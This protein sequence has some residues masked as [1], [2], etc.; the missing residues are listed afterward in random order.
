MSASFQKRTSNFLV[1]VLIGFIVISFMFTGYESMRGTP[2]TVARVGDYSVKIR[3]YQQEYQRQI[4]FYKN[5]FGG[6]DLTSAQI[7]QFGLKKNT[8]NNLVQRKLMLVLGDKLGVSP[9]P[10]QI[11]D[12][13]KK[14]PYFLTNK[15]FDINKYKQLLA[16]N[17]FT[18]TDFEQDTIQQVKGQKTQALFG[19]F[20]LSDKYLD[21]VIKFKSNKRNVSMVSIIREAM[22]KHVSVS[23]NEVNTFLSKTEDMERVKTMFN[24][25]KDSLSQKEQVRAHHILLKT[26]GKNDAAILKKINKVAAEVNTG[27]FKKLASKYTEDPSGK[28]TGGAL[29]WFGRGAMVPAFEKVAFSL[30]RG[31]ISSPV[32]TKFGYHIIYV[33]GKKRAKEAKLATH[34]KDIAKELIRRT[35]DKELEALLTSVSTQVRDAIYKGKKSTVERLKKKYGFQFEG[36]KELNSYDGTGGSIFIESANLKKIF[37]D[38]KNKRHGYVFDSAKGKQVVVVSPFKAKKKP[39]TPKELRAKERKGLK[40][41]LAKKLNEG[42]M[43]NLQDNVSVKVF[44]QILR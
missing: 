18:P 36:D 24:E 29:N 12:E 15:Q 42:M 31:S 35:K 19:E 5:I 38:D 40:F 43:K 11:K 26:D 37:T 28:K 14:L 20:P 9:G 4:G 30:K 41:V 2:D 21:E 44:D 17:G 3:E 22:R 32:K 27:N 7:E 13:I 33:T 25:R 6:K 39:D 1:T 10:M 16:A 23:N 34:K 8:I